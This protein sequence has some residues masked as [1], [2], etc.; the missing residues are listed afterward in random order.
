MA[1]LR[2][3]GVVR[4]QAAP[5]RRKPSVQRRMEG[6]AGGG[7]VSGSMV[8]GVGRGEGEVRVEG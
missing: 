4:P 2:M 8:D 3:K 6:E 5:T 1:A 7:G